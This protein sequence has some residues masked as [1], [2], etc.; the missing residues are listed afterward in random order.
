MSRIAPERTAEATPNSKSPGSLHGNFA[1]TGFEGVC[2]GRD[3]L[4]GAAISGRRA[5][6]SDT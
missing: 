4:L 3:S 5:S 2:P 1:S 6:C